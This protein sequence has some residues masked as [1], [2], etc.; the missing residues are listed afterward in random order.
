MF[1]HD[2]VAVT[3]AAVLKEVETCESSNRGGLNFSLIVDGDLFA[4][5]QSME[6]VALFR[7]VPVPLAY[8]T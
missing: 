4:G 6:S 2:G 3:G 7:G 5:E 1:Y 8:L